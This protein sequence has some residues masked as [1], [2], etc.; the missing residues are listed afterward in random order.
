MTNSVILFF[1]EKTGTDKFLVKNDVNSLL[2]T[3]GMT[4]SY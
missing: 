4:I 3:D 2:I 1:H